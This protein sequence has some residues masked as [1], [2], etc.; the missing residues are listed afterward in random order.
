MDCSGFL[1]WAPEFT[2]EL[3]E[4]QSKSQ[5]WTIFGTGKIET[6]RSDKLEKEQF[7]DA[8]K[9]R[10]QMTKQDHA[11]GYSRK[12]QCLATNRKLERQSSAEG[13]KHIVLIHKEGVDD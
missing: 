1:R 12:I 7:L 13:K 10:N 5:L 4:L 9:P 8:G 2:E 11:L 3:Q 6:K